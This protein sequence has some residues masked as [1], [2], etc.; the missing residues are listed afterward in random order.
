MPVKDTAA[1]LWFKSA[2]EEQAYDD[3]MMANIELTTSEYES[4]NYTLVFTRKQT[5]NMPGFSEKHSADMQR[6]G[7]SD[8]VPEHPAPDARPKVEDV[9]TETLRPHPLAH[10]HPR[11]R[12]L[13]RL[14]RLLPRS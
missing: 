8:A 1:K 2:D 5:E 10:V 3:M 14:G 9:R 4:P 7:P 12:P 11:S 6:V 13:G